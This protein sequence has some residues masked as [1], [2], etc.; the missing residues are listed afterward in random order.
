M[1]NCLDGASS[2]RALIIR[3]ADPQ[4]I[5]DVVTN[6]GG[7]VLVKSGTAEEDKQT[8]LLADPSGALFMIQKWPGIATEG[9]E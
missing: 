4:K 3:V 1:G 9:G 6:L 7:R 5:S 2:T 8:A